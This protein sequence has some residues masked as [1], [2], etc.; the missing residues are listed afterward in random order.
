MSLSSPQ[1]AR[2]L[3]E[4][5]PALVDGWVQKVFQPGPRTL[6]LEI[7]T[8]GKTLSILISV[9][10]ETA[11]IHMVTS[12][13]PNPAVPPSFCQYLRAHIQ[14]ARIDGIEQV[15]GDRIIRLRLTARDGACSLLAELTGRR[16]NLLLLDAHDHVLAALDREHDKTGQ[17]Y[18]PPPPRMAAASSPEDA[19][20][21]DRILAADGQ[22]G[23]PYPVSAAIESQYQ[24]RELE[25]ARAQL[26]QARMTAVRKGMKKA[27][28]RVEALRADLDKAGR[29][30]EYARYGELLKANLGQM[31]KGQ[32][33]ITV[34]D[35]YDPG[36][37]ELV[38]P[39]DPSKSAQGNMD[40][41]FKKHRKYLAADRE[42]R[43]RL[44]TAEREREAL[45]KELTA[46][47][48]GT[49]EPPSIPV[50][51]GK[52]ERKERPK[53]ATPARS[54]G[55][56]RRFTSADGLPIYVGRNAR[57]NDELTFKFAHTD[58]LWLHARGTPGSH[59][60]VRLEKGAQPP[61]ETV[62]DAATLALLYSDLKKSGKGEVIYTRRKW[63]KKM[64]GQPPGTVSVTQEKS[65][66]ATLDRNRLD[67]LKEQRDR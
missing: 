18:V 57:E 45:R 41:Y 40:D 23:L 22:R 54:P 67:R 46:L 5:S 33:K 25:L 60:I 32:D 13:L 42:I 52:K 35:Y 65:V 37:P 6:V 20:G 36:L 34:V 47:Q 2:V 51:P 10:S 59:V 17:S 62:K 53:T 19:S 30:S 3:S 9:A 27:A 15:S 31:T 28:R 1:I 39:L 26:R 58:D 48:T 66:H 61:P 38:L 64:K 16:S 4:I 12:K 21:T 11:R 14:G 7:R 50:F 56:Y 63:V 49:W 43:P 8:P 29:Y 44:E 24:E 55:P